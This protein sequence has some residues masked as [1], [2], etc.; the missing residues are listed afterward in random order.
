[1]RGWGALLLQLALCISLSSLVNAAVPQ[2]I[3]CIQCHAVLPLKLSQPV[4]LWQSSIH[5]EHGITCNA[6]HGGDPL[7]SA[8]AMTPARGYRGVPPP[9]TV[10]MLCGGCH[11]GV[12]KHYMNSA[13]GRALGKGG[14]TCVTCHG[15]H[16]IISASLDII[17]KKNCSPCHTFEKARM[18][19]SAMLK[20]EGMLKTI[21]NRI[22]I[23]RSQG[24]DTDTLEKRL[25]SLRNRFHSMYHSLDVNLIRQE[26]A[27][28]QAEL[29]KT[30][31]MGGAGT[32]ALVGAAAVS[33]ALL[34]ALLFYLIRKFLD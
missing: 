16:G 5:A 34:A 4:T 10:P 17:S 1:M 27:H 9:A 32:G 2:V 26:S 22:R 28:I 12:A 23:L 15:S 29:E 3:V 33:G 8:N 20:T 6:C 31:G 19:R 24:I 11:L 21:E 25:F 14:P 13:H 7:D 30:N 18:I